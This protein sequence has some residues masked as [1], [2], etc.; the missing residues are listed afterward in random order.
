MS[1]R[2]PSPWERNEPESLQ[3]SAW[4]LAHH[5]ITLVLGLIGVVL[6]LA[7][8]CIYARVSQIAKVRQHIPTM[9]R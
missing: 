5:I 2:R 6:S 9:T 1:N 7:A 8:W 4:L 3:L